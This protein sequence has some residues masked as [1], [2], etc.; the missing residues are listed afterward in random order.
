MERQT[1]EEVGA[2]H[3]TGHKFSTQKEDSLLLVLNASLSLKLQQAETGSYHLEAT[4]KADRSIECIFCWVFM[5]Q[6][7]VKK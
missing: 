3:L 7:N 4:Q 6:P 5:L 2:H 1:R